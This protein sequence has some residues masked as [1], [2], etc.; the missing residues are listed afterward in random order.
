MSSRLRLLC[1]STTALLSLSLTGLLLWGTR[2]DA[3]PSYARQTGLACSACHTT[4]P[5]LTPLGRQFKLNG[6]TLTG[7]K[8]ITSKSGHQNA[9]LSLLSELP[10]SAQFTISNTDTQQPQPGT[11]NG[12]FELPQSA[13]LF[14][15]GAMGEHVGSFIQVT[16]SSQD[17][18][19]SWDNTDIRFA[20]DRKF[21][22]KDLVWGLDFNNNPT[23]EDLWNDTPAWGYPWVSSDSAPSPIAAPMIDGGLAQDVAGVGGYTMFDQHLYAA[24]FIYRSEHIGGSQPNPGVGFGTN[25]TGLAPYWRLAWQQTRGNDYLEVGTYGMHVASIPQNVVGPRDYITDLAADFQWEHT[26]PWKT[27]NDLLTVHGDYIH[28]S[29][30]LLGTTAQGGAGFPAHDL[31]FAHFDGV[32]HVGNRFSIDAGPFWTTGTTDSTLFAP[33]PVSGSATG[34]PK[35]DGYILNFSYWPLQNIQLGL[36][37]TGYLT[38]NGLSANYDGSGRNASGNNGIYAVAWFVF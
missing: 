1:I 6:Y 32:Y 3:V 37:Y 18:H 28:E 24:G 34:N 33:G 27:R 11:Q 35:S 12:S 7:L 5:E 9:A 10:I 8:T 4:L 14:L 19:F 26:I 2:A 22:G 16:Y 20:R 36:E 23:V 13:S 17:D 31:N 15:A 25:I 38:F 21:L 29:S 30:E